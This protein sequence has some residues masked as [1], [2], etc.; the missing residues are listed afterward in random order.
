[1]ALRLGVVCDDEAGRLAGLAGAPA[2][3]DVVV[4]LGVP[5]EAP[6]APWVL[7]R[8]RDGGE[9]APEPPPDRVLSP[10]GHSV[11]RHAPWPVNDALFELP[12]PAE[13]AIAVAVENPD[14][15]EEL[16]RGI[17]DRA[18]VVACERLTEDVLR[19]A[20]V[21]IMAAGTGC[22][23]ARAFAVLAARRVLV[24][25]D[26]VVAFGL[27]AGRDHVQAATDGEVVLAAASVSRHPASFTWM[28]E[29]GVLA[30]ER[31]RASRVYARLAT[32]LELDG[33]AR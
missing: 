31:H 16:V 20:T 4:S 11:W 9:K 13:P 7:W 32:D 15:R 2:D 12:P 22:F 3:G 18:P 14:R 8:E 24:L 30:A 5:Q 17:G 25:D 27:L 6:S 29:L 33:L 21:V 1:M 23:P 19:R 28:R 10:A 26:H